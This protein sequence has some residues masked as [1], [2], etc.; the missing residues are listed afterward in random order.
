M[1][2]SQ[3]GYRR[4]Q[5]FVERGNNPRAVTPLKKVKGSFPVYLLSV[6]H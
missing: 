3:P 5:S 2:F 4:K 1:T 6:E